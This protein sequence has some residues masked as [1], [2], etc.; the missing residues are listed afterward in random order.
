[1][2]GCFAASR[3]HQ[4]LPPQLFFPQSGLCDRTIT[5]SPPAIDPSACVCVCE[6]G[7]CMCIRSHGRFVFIYA[8]D[9]LRCNFTFPLCV[10]PSSFSILSCARAHTHI[11]SVAN[12]VCPVGDGDARAPLYP[13][14]A[15]CLLALRGS[16]CPHGAA[17][18]THT[19]ELVTSLFVNCY[20]YVCTLLLFHHT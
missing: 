11:H 17:A 10:S 8:I 12:P 6:G 2:W 4:C 13:P 19:L 9:H 20:Y 5:Q 7:V 18:R 14:S 15:C 1:M 3:A 16:T